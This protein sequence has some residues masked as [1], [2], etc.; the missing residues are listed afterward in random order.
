MNPE[1]KEQ[2]ITALLGG[3]YLQGRYRLRQYARMVNGPSGREELTAFC[4]LGV[5]CDITDP[6]GWEKP[7][8]L[9]G[10]AHRGARYLPWPELYWEHGLT[11]EMLLPL[12][13][14]ADQEKKSFVEIAEWIDL[15]L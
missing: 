9:E 3:R 12:Q 4:P 15:H 6:D 13:P 1:T 7:G 14:M 10:W 2:W 8:H 11:S 5:F